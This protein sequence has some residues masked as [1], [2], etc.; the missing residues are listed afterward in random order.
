MDSE[1][2]GWH[3]RSDEFRDKTEE[4]ALTSVH[5]LKQCTLSYLSVLKVSSKLMS[6]GLIAAI[7]A[8]FELPPIGQI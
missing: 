6:A 8:V 1:N 7:M 2:I 4:E 3:L 5:V